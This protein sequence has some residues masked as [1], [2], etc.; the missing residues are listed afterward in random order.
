MVLPTV[1][2]RARGGRGRFGHCAPDGLVA[3]ADTLARQVI[4]PLRD[5]QTFANAVEPATSASPIERLAN[6]TGRRC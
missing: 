1:D 5:G 4:D 6:Y 2:E 3:A